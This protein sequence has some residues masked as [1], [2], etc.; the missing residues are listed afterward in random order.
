[1]K[2]LSDILA[3]AGLTVDGVVTLNN[4]ATGQTPAANDNSTKLA[5]TA[6]V[7]TFVQPYS[8]PIA[9]A[10]ILGGIKVGTGLSIDSG[11]GILS[12]TGASASS[13]KSTQTFVVTEGQTVFTVTNG[14]SVG[15]IDIFLNGVYLSPN[16]STATNGST[17][18]LNDAPATGDIIDVIVVSPVYQGTSTTTDQLPEG[19]VNLYYTNARARAAV[20]LTT[21]GVSGAA[22]YNSSTGVFNIPNYQGLVPSGGIAGDILAKVDGTNYNVAWIPN[23]TSQVQHYVKLGATMTAGTAVYVSGSTGGSGTNMIVSKASNASE[24]TSSKTLGLLKTGGATN[25]E[26]FVVTEGLLAGLDTSTAN[27]GDPVW[28]GVNG[29][30]IFGLLNKPTA[31]AHL[32][33]I[34]VVTRVQ[35]NNG[36]I[37]VKVQNGFE[38]D[39]L[40]DL[41]VKN[42]SDG[43]MIKYVASTGLWTKIAASTTN[44]VE[45]TN[46]YYTQARFDTAFS[47]KSTTNLS[48][49]TN[50]YYTQSRFDTAFAAKST[51]NLTE[52]TNLYYTDAR[53]GTYLTNNSYATQTYVNTAVSNLVD[54]A[55]GTLDTLNELAAALGDD[56]N[57]ATTVATSIGTKQAQ[58]NGTGFVK[59]S[60][61][62]VSYDN[63]NYY[64]ASN[65]N[66]YITGISF[67]N[68]SA[69]P[70]TIAG[71]GITDSLVYTTSTYS[72]PS[73]ITALAWS[74][75]TG[76]PAFITGYTETDTLATVTG[77]G[78]S[79]STA[80]TLNVGGNIISTSTWEK[81]KLV[82]TGVTAPARQGSDANGLNFTSN[83]LWNSGW[84]QDDSTRKSMAY[85][86]HLGNGRHEF[87]T[88]ASGGTVSWV[89]GLTIDEAGANF[90]VP[91]TVNSNIVYHAGNIPTWNQNTTGS[92]GSV[93]WT[94]VTGRPTALSSFTNDLGNYG[95]WITGYTETDTLQSVILRNGTTNTGFTIT[96]TNDTY[97][98]AASTNVPVIYLYNTG[99]TATSNAIIAL[100]T[101]TATGGDPILSFDIGGVIGWSMGIDNS[102]SDKFKIARSWA[103]L[104]SETRFS[105]ALDGTANFT[106][107]LTAAN[108][109]GTNTGDQ[110]NISGNA[111]TATNVAWTGVTGRPTALSSFSNDS[112]YITSSSGITGAAGRLSSRDLRTIAPNSEN[113]AELRFGFTS[114]TNNNN[115]PWA[116]Y[117]HLRSYSDGSGGSDN[118]VMFLKSGIGM[119]IWQQSFGSGTAYSSYVDVLHSSNYSSYAVPL[120]G[121]TMTGPLVVSGIDSAVKVQHDGTSTA[122]RGRIGSFNASAD[123]SSFLGNYTG[124]P[125]VFGHNNALTAWDELWVNTLG[126]YGQGNLYLSWFSYV[127]ANG[128]DT[129][130]AIWHAGNLTNLN[131]LTNG[132]GYIT[133]YTETDTLASVTARGA[134]TSTAISIN[135]TLT[136][137][138]GRIIARTGGVNTYGV[139]SGYDNSNHMMTF[140]ASVTGSTDSPTF[141]AVHQTTFVEYAEGNDTTGWFFKSA[142]TGTYQEIARIT[143]TGI[144]WNGNTVIHS[145]NIGSYTAGGVAWGNVSSKPSDIMYYA[146]FT[147]DA[148]TM[149]SNT[150]GFTYSVNAPLTGAIVKFSTGGGYDFQLNTD[151]YWGS[152]LYF[153]G[154]NGDLGV[155]RSWKRLLNADADPYAA[156]MNQYVR[157]TDNVTFNAVT[158]SA[159]LNLPNNGVVVVNGETD[160]W[161]ARFRTTTSTSNLGASLKNIIWTGGGSNEGF[162]ISGVGTGGAAFEVANNGNAWAKNNIHAQ[163]LFATAAAGRIQAGNSST[164]GMLYDSSRAAVVARG[165]YPHIELWADVSN[166]NHGGTLRFGGYNNGS[167]GDYKSWH[168]GTPGSDLYFMDIG[169]G[170]SNNSNPH[171]GIAGL[172]ASYGY[173]GAFTMMRFHNNGNIGIGNF[174]TYG[175]LGDNT[176]AYKLD[177][178]GNIAVRS[179]TASGT[180]GYAGTFIDTTSAAN[181]YVPFNF[182]NQYGDHS[183]G[184]VARF[185]IATSGQDKPAIQFTSA[186]SNDRWSIGYCTGSDFNFRITQNQGYRTDNSTNDGW[187]TERFRINTDGNTYCF[188]NFT[189][190]GDVTAYSD[191]RVK[192]DIQTVTD[193][194][195]KIKSIRGVT[196]KRNDT[197]DKNRK[198]LGVVAQ[199]VMDVLPEVISETDKGLFTV[200]YGNMA[201]LFIEA[202]KE[203]QAQ[204]ESQ[205]AEIEEL[206]DLVKQLIN[207]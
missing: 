195:E 159:N 165:S 167:S 62:T 101:N 30:L 12:V 120:S 88:S 48:E 60:G 15:L 57:F 89:T 27:A 122:W 175:S 203:Q 156:N 86:Q 172:G 179:T 116:D 3:K 79:T 186:G 91:L 2:F 202:I 144:N 96:N 40:H 83:A 22:T 136:V 112:G 20:S 132:P 21:T 199:E 99:T 135:N 1:M 36:E 44:I 84:S 34:G 166:S 63:S 131:Q 157:T 19:V 28:L 42:A 68:V 201:G 180:W 72:D 82:T 128:G 154:R 17:F 87:R 164:D 54:A 69:K 67:A 64:L 139:F 161:G 58:L 168:I 189:A 123:K 93:P 41:S 75:I 176:P 107:N 173:S 49:G 106:G 188:S 29:A 76:A 85:I 4:T 205:K 23:Y 90:N 94:G 100:R 16:Q 46:L 143:R 206:K 78:A 108:L 13:I 148:D 14:Y 105:M 92:A 18:T 43:D 125:G 145:G 47:A 155:W 109:S 53:V 117:L 45:G 110:T 10:S 204:I 194:I 187:G 133:S 50:L 32:V 6:W 95:G 207:R 9:S 121:G 151:Y 114:W 37:F 26:V 77:R 70:T 158:I 73:W 147:L 184:I 192:T 163:N 183:W 65:P 74:K 181:N 24:A 71:Y 153:R 39:E 7:R 103:A 97:S 162:A 115:A 126:I 177:I 170:G 185:H 171:A 141:T 33:F 198:H 35:Q 160:T 190:S 142:S 61:T 11:T 124:R 66:G 200:A 31:P 51:S 102:D 104:D 130:Y 80:I 129:N 55:P 134:S 59:V 152:Q 169:Y 98:T 149:P 52:G 8:L 38:L 196:F 138:N 174:G 5:T 193:P 178:R 25:D 113:A 150:T 197:E 119:R 81:W 191:I 137:T 146:G 182:V 118:L 56:P 127:K 111:A 140:R